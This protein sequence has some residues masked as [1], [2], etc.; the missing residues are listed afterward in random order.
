MADK[1]DPADFILGQAGFYSTE[2]ITALYEQWE[3]KHKREQMRRRSKRKR[4]RRQ[5]KR[6]SLSTENERLLSRRKPRHH[7]VGD[8][9]EGEDEGGSGD[10]END[11]PDVS[12]SDDYSNRSVSGSEEDEGD[13]ESDE[14]DSSSDSGDDE[15]ENNGD[16][17]ARYG[18]HK[19]SHKRLKKR[20]SR[21]QA[22]GKSGGG[23]GKDSKSNKQVLETRRHRC[24]TCNKR[25]SRPSQLETHK[26]T[27]T[28]QVKFALSSRP[29][30][31][32][33]V[34]TSCSFTYFI[35]VYRNLT[36]ASSVI[37]D[38]M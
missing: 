32:S 13:S 21:R 29:S 16:R 38:S 27:H 25:F 28:G 34:S 17:R 10:D 36:F 1:N 26:L 8:A 37:R 11:D 19:R 12:S 7:A 15:E 3:T 20:S 9:D 6:R 4:C 24:I 35:I 23:K 31:G 33:N 22:S 5:K 30:H 18:K 14:G 2:R